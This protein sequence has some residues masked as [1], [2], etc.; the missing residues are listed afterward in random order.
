M[1]GR[2][3]RARRWANTTPDVVC[4][5][6]DIANVL[7]MAE[8]NHFLCQVPSIHLKST[9]EKKSR[10]HL[11]HYLLLRSIQQN[12][13]FLRSDKAI[14]DKYPTL[15]NLRAQLDPALTNLRAQ[16]DGFR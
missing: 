10:A 16:L 15:T 4:D 5:T 1:I 8:E 11:A 9:A 12:A 7:C 2:A 14:E 13:S 3:H 6:G